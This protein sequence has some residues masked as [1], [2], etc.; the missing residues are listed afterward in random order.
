MIDL[1]LLRVLKYRDQFDKVARYIPMSDI[2]KKTKAIVEDITKYFRDNPEEKVIDFPAFRSM[3]FTVWHKGLKDDMCDYYNALL[4]KMEADVPDSVKNNMI[5]ALLELEF[6]TDLGN[7]VNDYE[8][9]EEIDI[10]HEVGEL[11]KTVTDNV[12]RANAFEFAAFEEDAVD[13]MVDQV[14]YK[15]H[16]EIMNRLYRNI[17]G[18][19]QYIIAARPGK[20]KTSFITHLNYAMSKDMADNKIIVWFN[21]ESTKK[22]IMSRQIQSALGATNKELFELR[23]A[24]KLTEQYVA[25][26]GSLDRVR[27]YD[28]HGKNNKYIEDILESIGADN[29]GAIIFD[30]L[31]NVKFPTKDG[32]REDQ[33]LEQLY[34]WSRELA[35]KYNCPS[36]PTS[37]I[38]NEGD[39]MMF[40]PESMLKDSKTGKQGACDGIIMIGS[41]HDPLLFQKRGLSMPKTKSKR[42][43]ENDM[44]EEV[45]FDADRGRYLWN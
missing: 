9:G 26:M 22:R 35:V 8:Q 11:Y 36:F 10:I 32:T 19:D 16:I 2:D 31:D 39:G 34:Q 23:N 5:N 15:W 20:G 17:L 45:L 38:S 43:G 29:I 13:S 14:G 30:M 1:A 7:L 42:E 3:F 24:G 44:R 21:N 37:Q 40:P 33:R 18:G 6:A 28:I 27:V 4:T 41:S 25:A 12:E